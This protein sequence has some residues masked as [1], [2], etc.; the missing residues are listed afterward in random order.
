[1]Y[2]FSFVDKHIVNTKLS[3]YQFLETFLLNNNHIEPLIK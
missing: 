2:L 3:V 1:M